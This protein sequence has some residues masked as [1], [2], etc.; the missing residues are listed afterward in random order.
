MV[1]AAG[2]VLLLL[3]AAA[4]CGSGSGAELQSRAQGAS[5]RPLASAPSRVLVMALIDETET[6]R[7]WEL[8]KKLLGGVIGRLK[9]GDGFGLIGI[10][11]SGFGPDDA[12]LP[13]RFLNRVWLKA[14]QEKGLWAQKV[15]ELGRRKTKHER[16]DLLGAIRHAAHFTKDRPGFRP[17][18]LVFSD[19]IQTPTMPKPSDAE[20]LRFPAGTEVYCLF[21]DPS[22]LANAF[23]IPGDIAWDAVVRIWR[24][25]FTQAGAVFTEFYQRA[26]VVAAIDRALPPR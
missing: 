18:I 1:V 2:T 8:S 15:S 10:D 22:E 5:P 26:D 12:R 25:I 23:K 17:V 19:M 24:P 14:Q 13:I 6:F 7:D 11:D 4:G 3:L 20:G 16:T 21:V 9:E